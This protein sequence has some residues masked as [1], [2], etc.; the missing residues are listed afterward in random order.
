MASYRREPLIY[1]VSSPSLRSRAAFPKMR[2]VPLM[3]V[4]ICTYH[5]TRRR[6]RK[7]AFKFEAA[8]KISFCF[9]N[10]SQSLSNVSTALSFIFSKGETG[11]VRGCSRFP[12]P[13]C[14]YS[15]KQ[16]GLTLKSNA[17][18]LNTYGIYACLST[19]IVASHHA[20]PPS[21]QSLTTDS[22]NHI[23]NPLDPTSSSIQS[24]SP[25]SPQGMTPPKC[26]VRLGSPRV[27]VSNAGCE[28]DR[29]ASS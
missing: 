3:H 11:Q 14:I 1:F 20:N 15:Y 4:S 25:R 9:F 27:G 8:C 12:C 17:F 7:G 19:N 22:Q 29:E 26:P 13:L 21:S 23:V 6:G 24:S 18:E 16:T 28:H 10:I 5:V 2:G